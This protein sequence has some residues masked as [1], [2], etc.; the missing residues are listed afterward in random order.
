MHELQQLAIEM[1]EG[2]WRGRLWPHLWWLLL[3]LGVAWKWEGKWLRIFPR[4]WGHH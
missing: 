1:G 3:I 4:W 2:G